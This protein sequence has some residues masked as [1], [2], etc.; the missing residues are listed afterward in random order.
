MQQESQAPSVAI[1]DMVNKLRACT[2]PKGVRG[3]VKLSASAEKHSDWTPLEAQVP[4]HKP[5]L[6]EKEKLLCKNVQNVYGKSD[7]ILIAIFYTPDLVRL[8]LYHGEMYCKKH[9]VLTAVHRA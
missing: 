2:I 3:K 4:L 7:L 9:G 6:L 8:D 1:R 5:A